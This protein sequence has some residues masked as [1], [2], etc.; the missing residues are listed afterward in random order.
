MLKEAAPRGSHDAPVQMDA[1][2]PD[3][4]TD[5][6]PRIVTAKHP[7]HLWPFCW[8]VAVAIDHFSRRVM[9]LAVFDCQP[10]S[11]QVRQ[12]LSRAM[13]E[14]GHG[15]KHLNLGRPLIAQQQKVGP[16]ARAGT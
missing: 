8:W 12:F 4:A 3:A 7:N 13:R 9:G 5:D 10:T 1:T 16:A 2:A 11:L 14:T 15:P 6:S